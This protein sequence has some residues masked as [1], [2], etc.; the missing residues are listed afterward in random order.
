[1]QDKI[2]KFEIL[3]R[4]GEGAMGTVYRA[5][6]PALDRPVALKTI[7]R[8]LLAERDVLERFQREARSAARL[9]HPNIVTIY[10][11]G[12]CE[13]TLYIAMELLEGIDLA[14]ALAPPNAMELPRK[15]KVI[16]DVCRGLDYAH[17]RGVV[18]RD[19]KPANIRLLPDDRVKIMDFGIA[20]IADSSLTQTGIV[21]GTPSYIAPEVLRSGRLDHRADVWAV[22][23]I[24]FEM[25]AGHRPFEAPTVA[26]LVYRIVH[27]P[28]PTL[29]TAR[30]GLPLELG[31]IVTHALAKD[32]RERYQDMTE[33]AQVLSAVLGGERTDVIT[34]SPEQRD[35]ALRDHVTEAKRLLARGDFEGALAAA[36]RAQALAPS[37]T[38]ILALVDTIERR[39]QATPTLIAPAAAAPSTVAPGLARQPSAPAA[40]PPAPADVPA[41]AIITKASAGARP[42]TEFRLETFRTRGAAALRE[43]AVFG[44]PPATTTACL[45][46]SRPHLATCGADGAIRIWDLSGRTLLATLRS[47]LHRRSGHDALGH[48]LAFSPDGGLLA[49]GHVD[50]S[51]H[52]WNVPDAMEVPVKLRHDASVGALAFSPDA[53]TLVSA[54]LDS[55]LKLWNVQ[56]ALTGD[57]RREMLR[58]PSGV[59]AL[60][61]SGDGSRLVTG[62]VNR[63]VRIL[64]AHT[65]RLTATLRGPEGRITLLTTTADGSG[66]LV[67]SQDRKLR[68][69]DLA[70]REE[71]LAVEC[72]RRPI[73]ALA[74]FDSGAGAV[75]VGLENTVTVWDLGG[76]APLASLWGRKDE[77]FVGV[78]LFGEPRQLAVALADGRIRVWG[79]AE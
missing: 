46:P 20:H 23:V 47:D 61:F 28:L 12:E 22:G 76:Q 66:C 32:P 56:A 78:A 69:F 13:G 73:V 5:R 44:D 15:L 29:P 41:P 50:G 58:Q 30:L 39:L 9:S 25:L 79:P 45:A 19:V 74:M 26:S 75:S 10:E 62:H 52:L 16:V 33:M 63:V 6:D 1:L 17:K 65:L 35:H 8:N 49:S 34:L 55:T 60:A 51:V 11:L 40:V 14:Q 36:R 2:G 59:T 53:T 31:E 7:S 71:R 70:S 37:R 38:E 77:S 67:A 57:A 21:L 4:L 27:D 24:L 64:D 54:S 3:A 42:V 43:Q 68:L 72:P 48:A 18:H